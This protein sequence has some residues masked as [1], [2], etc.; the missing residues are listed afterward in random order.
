MLNLVFFHRHEPILTARSLSCKWKGSLFW[1]KTKLANQRIHRMHKSELT[2]LIEYLESEKNNLEK[3]KNDCLRESDYE[4]AH[5]FSPAL[6]EINRQLNVLYNLDDPDYD[7]KSRLERY[8]STFD[9]PL[10]G[11]E[12]EHLKGIYAPRKK[13][14]EDQ[15]QGLN[16][17]IKKQTL[18]GQEFDDAVYELIEKRIT[19]FRLHLK[20][21]ENC[22]L[23]FMLNENNSILISSNPLG[24]SEDDYLMTQ[25]K[26]KMPELGFAFNDRKNCMEYSYELR[27]FKNSFD[28][29]V[30]VS[31]IVF[32]VFYYKEL[33]NPAVIEKY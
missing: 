18:D 4:G 12:C 2:E 5:Y 24:D 11:F 22:Y 25:L 3:Q 16:N 19:G 1:K 28:I 17:R 26:E 13:E 23:D 33:D 6:Q 29:K 7:E 20:R 9:I 31:R 10:E 21:K 32:D 30:L 27:T 15:I 8:K 14:L